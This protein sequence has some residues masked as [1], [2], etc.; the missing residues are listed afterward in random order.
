MRSWK[1]RDGRYKFMKTCKMSAQEIDGRASPEDHISFL[2][3]IKLHGRVTF[4][5]ER[6][7]CLS[8]FLYE[9]DHHSV[10][11]DKRISISAILP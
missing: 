6:I 3:K 10:D 1:I 5:P 4:H 7:L 2:Q 9:K 8:D 11:D